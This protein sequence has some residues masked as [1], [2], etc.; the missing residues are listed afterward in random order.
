MEQIKL[1][2]SKFDYIDSGQV[3]INEDK[4]K[5][6]EIISMLSTYFTGLMLITRS[7]EDK[8]CFTECSYIATGTDEIEQIRTALARLDQRECLT[9]V[10]PKKIDWR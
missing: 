7:L 5:I 6:Y 2:E 8:R 9:K 10:D 1:L 4:T 3:Y